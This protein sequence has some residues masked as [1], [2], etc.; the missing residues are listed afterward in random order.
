M[1]PKA[2][3]ATATWNALQECYFADGLDPLDLVRF[4]VPLS[5]PLHRG[6]S[7]PQCPVTTQETWI[8]LVKLE[9]ES[10]YYTSYQQTIPGVWLGCF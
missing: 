2:S 3:C 9:I 7:P 5:C 4:L 6:E 1:L 10:P 8:W